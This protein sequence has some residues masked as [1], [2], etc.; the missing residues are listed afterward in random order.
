[1]RGSSAFAGDLTLTAPLHR[2]EPTIFLSHRS[3]SPGR[4]GTEHS[5]PVDPHRE[6][7]RIANE[8]TEPVTSCVERTS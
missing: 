8:L 5:T 3:S 1:M 4:A 6:L 7:I 2:C